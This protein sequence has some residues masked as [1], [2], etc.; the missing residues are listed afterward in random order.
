MR[1]YQIQLINSSL[2]KFFAFVYYFLERSS[3][4]QLYSVYRRRYQI[5]PSFI[6]S[7]R[8]II[9]DGEGQIVIGANTYISHRAILYAAKDTSLRIGCNCKI[10]PD[11]YAH[12]DSYVADQSFTDSKLPQRVKG[13]ISVGDGCW[14]G[15]GVFIREG[16]T[17]GEDCA[18]GA[19]SV[20]T[21]DL[22][23]H[24]ICA[25]APCR[26]IKYKKAYWNVKDAETPL[27]NQI[28]LHDDAQDYPFPRNLFVV[29]D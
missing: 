2:R 21:R 12:T 14:I 15:Q 29:S 13:N 23:A 22:P 26:I 7:G 17:V 6:F 28:P 1:P 19:G 20:V 11:F 3:L 25:G 5:D 27:L 10:A 24:T 8:D 18:V 4:F 16:V 9:F